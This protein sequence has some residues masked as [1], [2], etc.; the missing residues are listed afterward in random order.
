MLNAVDQVLF[1][2]IALGFRAVYRFLHTHPTVSCL[3]TPPG[4]IVHFHLNVCFYFL[5]FLSFCPDVLLSAFSRICKEFCYFYLLLFLFGVGRV[6]VLCF[7]FPFS[8]CQLCDYLQ[9]IA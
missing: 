3:V 1:T 6:F 4:F 7:V 2:S 9:P 8:L 5:S